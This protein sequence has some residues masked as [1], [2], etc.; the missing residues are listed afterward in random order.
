MNG[1]VFQRVNDLVNNVPC[2]EK[3]LWLLE[4]IEGF[5]G[6]NVNKFQLCL[7]EETKRREQFSSVK[8]KS[9]V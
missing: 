8:S 4:G 9:T 7:T 3:T 6:A 1:R 5:D 2:E